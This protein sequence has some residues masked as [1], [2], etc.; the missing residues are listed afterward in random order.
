MLIFLYSISSSSSSSSSSAKKRTAKIV[1][2]TVVRV[3]VN[4]SG[5]TSFLSPIQFLP[6]SKLD[7]AFMHEFH[8]FTAR[9]EED[10][11]VVA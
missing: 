8:V 7:F 5:V 1:V 10:I 3:R 6:D 4:L 2:P 11:P 9:G